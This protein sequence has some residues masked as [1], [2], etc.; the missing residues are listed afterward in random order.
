MK[1]EDKLTMCV[2]PK[3]YLPWPKCMFLSRSSGKGI[4]Q[5][6]QHHLPGVI[7]LTL[8][9]LNTIQEIYELF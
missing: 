3:I 7:S 4:L 6:H 5:G 9:R 8:S 1:K 2:L